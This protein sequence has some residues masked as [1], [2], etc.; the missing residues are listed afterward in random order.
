MEIELKV[1]P[2]DPTAPGSY[3][4][5]KRIMTYA[6][7]VQ[8]AIEGGKPGVIL[9]ALE[10]AEALIQAHLVEGDWEKAREHVSF[11]QV[12][13]LLLKLVGGENVPLPSAQ[14]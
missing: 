13:E 1:K 2:L 5:F 10:E 12:L 8:E 11:Q 7:K 14:Q 3:Q 9:E 4:E 6:R